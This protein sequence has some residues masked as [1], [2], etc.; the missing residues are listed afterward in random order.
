[1]LFPNKCLCYSDTPPI[2]NWSK[3]TSTWTET[4]SSTFRT[5]RRTASPL[6]KVTRTNTNPEVVVIR[7]TPD[8]KVRKV[9][10]VTPDN[11]DRRDRQARWAQK[12]QQVQ[13]VTRV[14]RD[15]GERRKTKEIP[16]QMGTKGIPD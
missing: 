4:G 2:W 14:T 3:R 5:R 8:H 6:R 7:V 10:R 9:I 16:G 1:M 15:Q 12:D 13:K 11:K